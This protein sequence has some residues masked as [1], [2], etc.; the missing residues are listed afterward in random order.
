MRVAGRTRRAVAVLRLRARC[1]AHTV[2]RGHAPSASALWDAHGEPR[3]CSICARL[4]GRTRP[5]AAA[6]RGLPCETHA[7]QHCSLAV[8][9]LRRRSCPPESACVRRNGW[10]REGGSGWPCAARNLNAEM[11]GS[12]QPSVARNG[13]AGEGRLR[14]AVCAAQRGRGG[15]VGSDWPCAR[16][17]GWRGEGGSG[18]PCA[19]RNGWRTEGGSRRPCAGRNGTRGAAAVRRGSVRCGAAPDPHRPGVGKGYLVSRTRKPS[20]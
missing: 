3:S 12:G 9:P 1:G 5:A 4:A 18:W 10:P 6:L 15:E 8:C 19:A 13:H 11:I 17:N 16:R 14:L 7:A 2:G 20:A